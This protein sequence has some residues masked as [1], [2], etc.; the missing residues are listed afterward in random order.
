MDRSEVQTT[1][2]RIDPGLLDAAWST[3]VPIDGGDRLRSSNGCAAIHE[4]RISLESC[5]LQEY[6]GIGVGLSATRQRRQAC[7]GRLRESTGQPRCLPNHSPIVP[8]VGDQQDDSM[9]A[10]V[11]LF[12]AESALQRLN[13]IDPGFSFDHHQHARPIYDA[14]CASPITLH[15]HGNL[16]SPRESRRQ[17][18]PEAIQ[19]SDVRGIA[20]GIAIWMEACAELQTEGRRQP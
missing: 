2:E 20:D 16:G 5:L 11:T 14:I 17:P 8:R 15:G 13:I 10:K 6:Q 1:K 9:S 12:A 3:C 4:V 19:Q 7:S 18:P